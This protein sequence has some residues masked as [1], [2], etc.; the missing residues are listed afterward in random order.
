[1]DQLGSGLQTVKQPPI[2]GYSTA[3][4]PLV[5]LRDGILFLLCWA[6]WGMALTAV[7]NAIEWENLGISIV[8]W[9]AA[10]LAFFHTLMASFHFPGEYFLLVII[11]ICSFL[12][13]TNLGMLL[14]L[15]TRDV[16]GGL[17]ALPLED[18]VRHFGLDSTLI[19]PMQK[20]GRVVVMH[21][22][23]GQITGVRCV[24]PETAART[25]AKPLHL[26]V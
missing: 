10:H 15:R 23:S 5:R 13:W 4:H 22:S 6:M 26:V 7:A 18:L 14:S 11:L 19:G 24:H 2:F 21:S 3:A 25:E 8:E 1:V 17:G 9:F 20:E 16:R 12:I